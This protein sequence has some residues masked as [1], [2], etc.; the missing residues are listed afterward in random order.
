M[1]SSHARTRYT[2]RQVEAILRNGIDAVNG[3]G[4]DTYGFARVFCGAIAYSLF[5]SIHTAFLAKSAHGQDDLGFSWVDL[6][7]KYKAYGRLDSRAGFS[8]PGPKYRPTLTAAQDR[9]WRGIFARIMHKLKGRGFSS[10][11]ERQRLS[12]KEY[13]EVVKA[14]RQSAVAT[15]AGAAWNFVK[16]HMEAT[17]LI[18]LCRDVQVPILQ[19]THR[20]VDSLEPAPLLGD[21]SYR[22][23]NSD[24]IFGHRSVP[25]STISVPNSSLILG[26]RVPYAEY[27]GKKRP[28]WPSHL[29]IWMDRAISAGRDAVNERLVEVLE[30]G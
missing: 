25:G 7:P 26:T 18:E 1:A 14:R 12:R 30:R 15:A 8:L 24:Q 11:K 4:P 23:T 29:G 21:S 13:R 28:L 16:D 20:L 6:T 19:K 10:R 17:T 3:R 5:N 27:V 22:P 9:V 2:R